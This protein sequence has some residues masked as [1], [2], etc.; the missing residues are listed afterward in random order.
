MQF[1][2][3]NL[4]STLANLQWNKYMVYIVFFVVFILFSITLS[5]KG[6]L[7][8]NNLMNVLRQ[9]AM[10]SIM[11]VAGTFIIASG[12][13][14]LT[15]GAVAAMSAMI[16]SL[17]LQS[18][19]SIVLALICGLGFGLLI[20]AFNGFLVTKL[21][22]PSF[23]ATMGMMSAIRGTAM[24][25]TN[26]AAVPIKNDTFTSI[27]GI[28]EVFG[29][30]VLIIWTIIFYAIGIVVFNKTPFGR[31]V[32]ATGGNELSATYS[33]VKTQKIKLAIFIISGVVA[34]FAGILYAGR[35]QAG[36]FSFGDGDE[37]SVIAAVVLGGT[38]MSGG[39]GSVIGALVGS[40]LMGLINNGLILG[41]LT[42]AQQTIVRGLIIV[43]AV[44]LSN[45]TQGKK[46]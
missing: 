39:T 2:R 17:V 28:G 4:K 18:T 35:M 16:V 22:L 19:D 21:K 46:K 37:M 44:A 14:D 40:V 32:L 42:S 29:I 5:D 3:N 33:G 25:V 45:I 13:I 26:T 38:A 27:F 1:K 6:F 8:S 34:A 23:L 24:W 11:A 7:S 10:I 31:H 30:S 41:G 43:A 20:G 12:Q 9:T 15:V 36:R